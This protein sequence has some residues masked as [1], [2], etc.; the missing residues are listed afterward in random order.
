MPAEVVEAMV[1]ASR[2]FVDMHLL[3]QRVGEA[4]ANLT[5]N[6]AALVCGRGCRAG[7]ATAACIAGDEPG[8]IERLPDTRGQKNEVIIHRCQRNAYDHAIRQAGAS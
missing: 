4:I 7:S 5:N 6:G 3:H 1:E 8:L 2:Y